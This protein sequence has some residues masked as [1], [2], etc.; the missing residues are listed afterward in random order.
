ML[1]GFGFDYIG[2]AQPDRLNILRAAFC[3]AMIDVS[4]YIAKD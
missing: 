2:G 3:M 1:N 4:K